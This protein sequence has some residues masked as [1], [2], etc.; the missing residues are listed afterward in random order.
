MVKHS[1]FSRYLEIELRW[2]IEVAVIF[3]I[4]GLMPS[5]PLAFETVKDFKIL[6]ALSWDKIRFSRRSLVRYLVS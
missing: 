5:G 1:L 4:L 6:H 3:S 2:V